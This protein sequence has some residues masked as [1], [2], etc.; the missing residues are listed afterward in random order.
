MGLVRGVRGATLA[1]LLRCALGHTEDE[2]FD[3]R[4]KDAQQNEQS[5]A[6]KLYDA[7][8]QKEFGAGFAPRINECAKR[9]GGP[10]SDP[11]DVLMKL[12]ATGEVEEALV[13]PRT[14]FSECF[15]ELSKKTTF[16]K[17]PSAG[18]WVVARMRFSQQ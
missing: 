2:P 13:R 4:M 9:T 15:T 18:Y 7:A 11:F 16:P 12:S 17:P 3:V 14:Q 1:V 6:G 10:H 8:F 5:P